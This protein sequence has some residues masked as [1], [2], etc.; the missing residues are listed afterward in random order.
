MMCDEMLFLACRFWI[1]YTYRD[2][3]GHCE[4]ERSATHIR[5]SFYF[6]NESSPFYV[7]ESNVQNPVIREW[8]R[9]D[10]AVTLYRIGKP[11]LS[12]C[13]YKQVKNVL[14]KQTTFEWIRV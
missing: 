13:V 5:Y 8:V 1:E 12:N 6:S 11:I 3:V 14:S 9:F 2:H 7:L 10:K 4:K